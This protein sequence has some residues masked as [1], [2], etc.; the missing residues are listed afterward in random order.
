M[1]DRGRQAKTGVRR[2]G[3]LEILKGLPVAGCH[4]PQQCA[5]VSEATGG[6]LRRSG[7][8]CTLGG[9][10]ERQPQNGSRVS[11]PPT[12]FTL[13]EVGARQQQ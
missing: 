6:R 2:G 10:A 12:F 1:A 5:G 3:G 4:L 13:W 9:L 8:G 11:S 7:R